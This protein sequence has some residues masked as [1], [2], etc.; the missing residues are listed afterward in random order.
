MRFDDDDFLKDTGDEIAE[1]GSDELLSDEDLRLPDEASPL[2]RLHA[3]RAW[4]TRQR[5]ETTIEIGTAALSLQEAQQDQNVSHLR[6]REMQRIEAQRQQALQDLQAAQQRLTAFEEA[7]ELLTECIVHTTS[8]ERTLVEYYLALE[9][10]TL[11]EQEES[12][13]PSS[14][15]YEALIDVLQRVEHVGSPNEE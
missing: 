13:A 5:K 9:E 3:V 6:R 10:L 12:Q 15:R 4:L 14:P 7:E 1:T 8:N 2:V 11:H